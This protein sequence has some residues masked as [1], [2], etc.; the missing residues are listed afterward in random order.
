MARQHPPHGEVGDER[1]ALQR[2]LMVDSE[3]GDGRGV[4]HLPAHG[5]VVGAE[6]R[7]TQRL[8]AGVS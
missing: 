3:H 4:P 2:P 7:L 1:G 8:D 5:V 6:G